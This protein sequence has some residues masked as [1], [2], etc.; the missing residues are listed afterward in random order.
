[1]QHIYMV[2]P[3]VLPNNLCSIW[4]H[5]YF[6]QLIYH[7]C[8]KETTEAGIKKLARNQIVFARRQKNKNNFM[9]LKSA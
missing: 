6:F 7:P 3:I 8:Y 4:L 1:M 9:Q 2:R 5:N